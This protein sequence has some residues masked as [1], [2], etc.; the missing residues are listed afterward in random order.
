[1]VLLVDLF[2][3]W[4]GGWGGVE[5]KLIKVRHFGVKCPTNPESLVKVNQ[6]LHIRYLQMTKKKKDG[7]L[8]RKRG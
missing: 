5:L 7:K 6:V 3:R 8:E 4:G 2:G 1:M